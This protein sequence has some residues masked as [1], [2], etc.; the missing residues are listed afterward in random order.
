[1]GGEKR[2]MPTQ[3]LRIGEVAA[4][5]G[6]RPATVRKMLTRGVLPRIRPTKR[7]VR[8]REIDVE[9]LIRQGRQDPPRAQRVRDVELNVAARK[10]MGSVEAVLDL[11]GWGKER[12]LSLALDR[13]LQLEEDDE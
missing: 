5:L 9:A 10:A 13:L 8:V 11:V 2:S 1:M 6:L 12:T 3:L 4:R 7:A